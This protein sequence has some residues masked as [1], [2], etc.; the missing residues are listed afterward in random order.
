[1]ASVHDV[2]AYILRQCGP[3]S[4]MKLQ[5]LVYYAQAWHLVWVEEPLF[6]ERI[7]AWANGPVS[8]DLYRKHRGRFTVTD[9]PAGDPEVLD[10]SERGTVDAVLRTYGD[11][12]GRKLSYLTHAEG[13]WRDARRGL[14]PTEI[15]DREIE[16]SA[17]QDYYVAVDA[18]DSAT[19]VNQLDWGLWEDER[20][21]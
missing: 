6:P 13:P 14:H 1:M 12:E 2:A 9:W 7:E 5:K 19:P 4:T 18:D 3:M 16:K 8:P 15:S 11:L 20:V 10:A 21:G 17:M